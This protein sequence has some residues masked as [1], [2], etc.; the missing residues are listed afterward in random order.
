VS[1]ERSNKKGGGRREGK[2]GGLVAKRQRAKPS[3]TG[4][5]GSGVADFARSFYLSYITV[6]R[7]RGG[8]KRGA[9][10]IL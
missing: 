5:G 6:S 4:V 1:K 2:P 8:V 7:E 9:A 3:P 10:K